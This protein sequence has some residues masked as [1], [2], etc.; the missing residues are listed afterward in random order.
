MGIPH[1]R[2][3]GYGYCQECCIPCLEL[4]FVL[5][6]SS[7]FSSSSSLYHFVS[8]LFHSMCVLLSHLPQLQ[9]PWSLLQMT[10]FHSA[11][12]VIGYIIVNHYSHFIH[13]CT[14]MAV[15]SYMYF[16]PG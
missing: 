3:P 7:V 5:L 13:L 16:C 10:D 14:I 15:G 4:A 11:V 9:H 2:G 1:V 8:A 6:S 12:V